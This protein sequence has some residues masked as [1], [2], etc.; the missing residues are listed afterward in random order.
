EPLA[1]DAAEVTLALDG[2]VEHGVA[3]DDRLFGHDPGVARRIDDDAAAREALADVVVRLAFQF[4][5]HAAREP[6]AETLA[7]RADELHLHGVVRKPG[8][9]VDFRNRAREH[10]ARGA[11]GVA[12]R[13]L[14][15]HRRAAIDRR[16]GL[17][18]QLAIEDLLDHVVLRLALVDV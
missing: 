18:D 12:D 2:T 13:R 1:G 8:V 16:T 6:R 7:G 3:D 15:A 5:R 17:G 4:E 9:A 11:V 14:E 10:R